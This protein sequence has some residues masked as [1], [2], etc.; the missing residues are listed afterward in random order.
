MTRAPSSPI[1]ET[2]GFPSAN[3]A[4]R[5]SVEQCRDI[6]HHHSKS[7]SLASRLLPSASRD[8]AVIVYA[9]CRRADDAIDQAILPAGSSEEK[10][11]VL[12]RILERL[13]E[14]LD[15]LYAGHHQ[16]DPVLSPFQ[17]VVFHRHIPILYPRELLAGMEMDVRPMVYRTIDDLLLYCH[18]V[19]GIVGLMMCHV[20][21]IADDDALPHAAHM[22]LAMQITNICRDVEEDWQRGRCYLPQEMLSPTCATVLSQPSASTLPDQVRMEL[23]KPV[24]DLLQLADRYYRS[25]DAGLKYLDAT[26]AWAIRTARLV[27]SAIGTRLARQGFDVGSGRAIVPT[28]RKLLL[29][30]QS[31]G[32]AIA[33]LPK[34]TFRHSSPQIPTRLLEYPAAVELPS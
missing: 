3:D 4:M 23:K 13:R 25:G 31:L 30:V 1:I 5:R 24:H 27:Y 12:D 15:N 28:S 32:E 19:A 6:I 2:G 11:A 20:L 34:R 10:E 17:Q 33:S 21:G 9:W 14:E 18:R 8:N 16:I 29:V 22:G 7:F 26:S